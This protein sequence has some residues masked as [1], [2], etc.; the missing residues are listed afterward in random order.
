M[1]TQDYKLFRR[2][3]AL[4]TFKIR[5]DQDQRNDERIRRKR[6][7]AYQNFET[8]RVQAEVS[9]STAASQ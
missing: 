2:K 8:T 3:V 6:C 9:N 1:S 5:N 7:A 4:L